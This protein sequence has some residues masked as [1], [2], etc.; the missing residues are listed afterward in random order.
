MCVG[1]EATRVKRY[2][3]ERGFHASVVAWVSLK[4]DFASRARSADAYMM[5]NLALMQDTSSRA[6]Q[7]Q[8]ISRESIVTGQVSDSGGPMRSMSQ[9]RYSFASA[10]KSRS[11]AAS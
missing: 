7:E 1:L 10:A 4:K 6:E 9:S 11:F 8:R 2:L 5:N 3:V